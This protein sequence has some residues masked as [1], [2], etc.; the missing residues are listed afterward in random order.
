MNIIP[1]TNAK[2]WREEHGMVYPEEY[3]IIVMNNYYLMMVF[4]FF[5]GM[6]MG[7][8]I[9]ELLHTIGWLI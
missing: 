3:H 9:N 4:C 8:G 6:G 1:N 2:K 5:M 7:M